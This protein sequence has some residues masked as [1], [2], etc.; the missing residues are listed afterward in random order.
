MLP[1]NRV[2]TISRLNES[3]GKI[4]SEANKAL[5]TATELFAR[6]LVANALLKHSPR[7]QSKEEGR[8]GQSEARKKRH[9]RNEE[10]GALYSSGF[11]S[12]GSALT[13]TQVIETISKDEKYDFL[14]D[15]VQEHRSGMV[16]NISSVRKRK[17]KKR[18]HSMTGR[19]DESE[20]GSKT[21]NMNSEAID[22][23]VAA[24]VL[25]I[26]G[27]LR[28][29]GHGFGIEKVNSGG[30]SHSNIS[31]MSHQ[32]EVMCNIEIDD[33]YDEINLQ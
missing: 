11:M 2:K 29:G 21:R 27:T 15:V 9:K 7:P 12:G 23:V 3:V 1:L 26:E 30:V 18:K 8:D 22:A 6:N 16:K 4:S 5:A 33:D 17:G 19:T 14:E 28:G 20:Y 25:N 24:Q 31:R 32:P 10:S 13:D